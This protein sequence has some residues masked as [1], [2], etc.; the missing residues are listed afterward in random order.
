M[1]PR[2]ADSVGIAAYEVGLEHSADV[3]APQAGAAVVAENAIIGQANATVTSLAFRSSPARHTVWT[4]GVAIRLR[5]D[6]AQLLAAIGHVDRTD[7]TA[8]D[9]AEHAR[10][11]GEQAEIA[12]AT[13]HATAIPT[14]NPRQTAAEHGFVP[15]RNALETVRMG[16]AGTISVAATLAAPIL[17]TLLQLRRTDA[18]AVLTDVATM[19]NRIAVVR[20]TLVVLA[21]QPTRTSRAGAPAAIRTAATLP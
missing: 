19:A 4:A 1:A 21:G 10:A 18:T 6:A 3:H 9:I 17:V 5:V 15:V 7:T 2:L 13:L 11:K 8:I 14:I 12:V 20:D 16:E